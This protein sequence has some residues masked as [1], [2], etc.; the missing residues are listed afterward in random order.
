MKYESIFE[1]MSKELPKEGV[2]FVLI[3]GFAVSHY[4]MNRFTKDVDFMIVKE[5]FQKVSTILQDSGYKEAIVQGAFARFKGQGEPFID[6][7]IMFVDQGT[8]EGIFSDGVRAAIEGNEFV[9]PSMMHLIALKIH[10]MKNNPA[11]M[12]YPDLS[13]ILI[14]AKQNNI[15]LNGDDFRELCFTYGTEQIYQEILRRWSNMKL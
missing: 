10:A 3:G 7:D 14:I 13:D 4:G 9:L 12:E 11:R 1:L 8:F 2:R 5:D 6:V 15:N